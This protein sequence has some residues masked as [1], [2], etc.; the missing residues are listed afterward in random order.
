MNNFLKY[1]NPEYWKLKTILS[2]IKKAKNI[3]LVGR[4]PYICIAFYI[5][6]A[7]RYPSGSYIT[8]YIPEFNSKFLTGEEK[9]YFEPWWPMADMI[10]RTNAL[11]TLI[12]IYEQK[13]NNF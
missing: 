12:T 8:K 6:N 5:V 7:Y 2:D 13:I 1:L 10:S 4:T 9:R 11:N 3:I